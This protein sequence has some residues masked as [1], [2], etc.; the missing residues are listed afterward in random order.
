MTLVESLITIACASQA[1]VPVTSFCLPN[2]TKD[3]SAD[4]QSAIAEDWS[5]DLSTAKDFQPAIAEE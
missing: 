4:F 1:G 5:K 3:F 2:T